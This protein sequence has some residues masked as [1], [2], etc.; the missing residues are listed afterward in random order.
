MQ[1]QLGDINN[2][3]KVKLCT[4]VPAAGLISFC[5][6]VQLFIYHHIQLS[7]VS[8]GFDARLEYLWGLL[9]LRVGVVRR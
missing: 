2:L 1:V 8:S 3:V 7:A 5:S 4:Y 9:G 6:P